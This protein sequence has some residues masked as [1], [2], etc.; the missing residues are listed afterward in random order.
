MF[1]I[2]VRAHDFASTS[3]EDLARDIHDYNFQFVQL[4]LA[5]SFAGF[6]M[7]PAK[8]TPGFAA[9]VRKELDV[10]DIRVAVLGCYIN[11]AHPDPAE[12]AKLGAWFK[13]HLRH[14]R[15]FGTCLVATETGS[16][17]RDY[18]FHEDN[19][20][21]KAFSH[22]I[23]NLEPLVAEAERFGV[24]V[25]IEGVADHIINSPE[26]MKK[27]LDTINSSNLKVIFDPVNLI[28]EENYREQHKLINKVFDLYGSQVAVVHAKDFVMEN[29]IKKPRTLG[30]GIFDYKY[31]LEFLSR[32][33]PYI[34]ILIEE[35]SPASFTESYNFLQGLG[36]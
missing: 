3:L 22:F 5:K 14:A 17:N 24:F 10:H 25:A 2:G 36:Q 29:G 4:A 13:M 34:D 9:R 28:T 21:A 6:G 35:E 15:D 11:M 33:K 16:L 18:S 27:V 31:F 23:A 20:S 19:F 1:N 7:N 30:K 26:R 32:Q 8:I 12:M